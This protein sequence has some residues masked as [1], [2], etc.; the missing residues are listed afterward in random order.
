MKITRVEVVTTVIPQV[1]GRYQSQMPV[2]VV[3]IRTDTGIDGMGHTF[4]LTTEFQRSLTA[5]VRELGELV[6]GEDP[7]RVEHLFAK[8]IYPANFVGPGG[9]LNIAATA[10]DIALWDIAGKDAG[11]PLW[12]LLGGYSDHARTY[13]SSTA[14]GSRPDV[15]QR[16]AAELVAQGHRA[17]KIRPYAERDARIDQVV[18]RV[19]AIR[20]AIGYD[21]DLMYDVNQTW[22][23][24]R[25][26]RVGRALEEYELFWLE[27]PTAMHDIEGQA[28]IAQALDVP[29]CSGEYHYNPVSLLPLL[30]ARAVDYLMVDMCRMG[31]ITQF[32]KAA[33]LAESFGVPV[34]SHLIPEVFA[35][36][37]AAVPNGLVAEWMDWSTM[38]FDGLP[39]L[40]DGVLHL[41]ERPGHGLTLLEDV[42]QKYRVE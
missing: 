41:S 3:R 36:C 35:H 32:R 31:G 25:A 37:I 10:I 26:I 19:R 11:Q 29:I 17:I 33:A 9:L 16:Q 21:I 18:A 30:K 22:T 13:Q 12:R 40:T 5:M 23:P 14:V 42:V 8:M 4:T 38:L 2:V 28:A 7:R 6:V 34:A 1:I 20:E 39:I 27:D 24:S 15:L